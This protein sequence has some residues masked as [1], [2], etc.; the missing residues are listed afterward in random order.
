MVPSQE[1]LRPT[2]SSNALLRRVQLIDLLG[3]VF[4]FWGVDF[5]FMLFRSEDSFSSR[6]FL[7]QGISVVFVLGAWQLLSALLHLFLW[8]HFEASRR[9]R[10]LHLIVVGILAGLCIPTLLGE[11]SFGEDS[12]LDSIVV[13]FGLLVLTPVLAGLYFSVTALDLWRFSA[14]AKGEAKNLPEGSS[15]QVVLQ[16]LL[17]LL[18]LTAFSRAAFV[19]G[20]GSPLWLLGLYGALL[21]LVGWLTAGYLKARRTGQ[22]T[23]VETVCVVWTAIVLCY[24]VLE[25]L[26]AFH[27]PFYNSGIALVLNVE[28]VVSV[29]F[30]A[31]LWQGP[32]RAGN[33]EPVAE[34]LEDA[35]D[36]L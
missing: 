1:P 34:A 31:S 28:V 18:L 19:L 26:F 14:A 5:L 32:L 23:S 17:L 2:G 21:G 11:R 9:P 4:C 20:F 33:Q 22:Q 16:A 13:L 30:A 36:L 35:N 3:Q 10:R 12:I 29:W 8:K 7:G 6:S 24:Y 15:R 27:L 25:L